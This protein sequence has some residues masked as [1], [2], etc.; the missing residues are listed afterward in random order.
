MVQSIGIDVSKGKLDVGL[1]NLNQTTS[2]LQC[3]NDHHSIPSL[4]K[5][6]QAYQDIEDIPIVIE[7]TGGYHYG[8]TFALIEKGFK[9]VFVINPI[10]TKKTLVITD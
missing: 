1:I 8:I 2:N 5:T 6:L 3:G 9:K 7:A 4:V 10:I